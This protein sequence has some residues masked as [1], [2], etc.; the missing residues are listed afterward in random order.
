MNEVNFLRKM[1][2]S[3]KTVRNQTAALERQKM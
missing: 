2:C 3:Q 1:V